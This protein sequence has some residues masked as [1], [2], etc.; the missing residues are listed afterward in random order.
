MNSKNIKFSSLFIL[1]LITYAFYS[2]YLLGQINLKTNGKSI[3]YIYISLTLICPF[4]L[5]FS[6]KKL[7]DFKNKFDIL[8]T[9]NSF[10]I[11]KVALVLYL[12]ISSTFVSFYTIYFESMYFYNKYNIFIIAL[13]LFLPIVIFSKSIIQSTF[14]MHPINIIIYIFFF[15]LFFS[16]QH[17]I[18]YYTLSFESFNNDNLVE[19]IIL[20]IPLIFEPFILFYLINLSKEEISKKKMIFGVIL[21]SFTS[22]LS[23]FFI[24]NQFG[25]LL[26]YLDFPFLQAW[27]NIYINEYIENLDCFNIIL[28]ITNC[29]TRLFISC[30]IISNIFKTNK[31][32]VAIS[33]GFITLAIACF[34]TTN[35]NV[36]EQLKMPILAINSILLLIIAIISLYYIFRYGGKYEKQ[37]IK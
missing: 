14:H 19:S 7:N 4:I 26:N 25:V 15:Y 21:I 29:V 12:L 10:T 22:T 11:I 36:F 28:F 5:L 17:E 9:K 30:S 27:R 23:F 8:T 3:L 32:F 18:K 33:F 37:S 35:Q 6:S 34:F 20:L 24:G 2:I 16:N 13:I 1:F 31:P